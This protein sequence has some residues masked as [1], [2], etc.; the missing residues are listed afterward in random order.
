VHTNECYVCLS[1]HKFERAAFAN[2]SIDDAASLRTLCGDDRINEL[3]WKNLTATGTYARVVR[4]LSWCER[5][6][7][8]LQPPY[9]LDGWWSD[10]TSQAHAEGL[11]GGY[12]RRQDLGL[13]GA[14]VYREEAAVSL[15]PPGRTAEGEHTVHIAMLDRPGVMASLAG[16]RAAERTRFKLMGLLSC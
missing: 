10:H 3:G 8:G 6:L 2:A 14:A 4:G 5:H 1:A 16:M 13:A 15:L 9:V 11:Q 7:A 12:V